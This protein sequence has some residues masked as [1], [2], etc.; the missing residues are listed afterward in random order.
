MFFSLVAI[1]ST[2][3]FGVLY[4]FLKKSCDILFS[5]YEINIGHL[6]NVN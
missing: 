6:E 2:S 4:V 3:T 5:N 1:D